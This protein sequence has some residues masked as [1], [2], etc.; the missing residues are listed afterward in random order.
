MI[1]QRLTKFFAWGGGLMFV[2]VPNSEIVH[3]GLRAF[4]GLGGYECC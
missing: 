3:S 4:L 2:L 1:Q